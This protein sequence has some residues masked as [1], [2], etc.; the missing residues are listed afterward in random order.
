VIESWQRRHSLCQLASLC[1]HWE[2]HNTS[3]CHP[4]FSHVCDVSP[5]S[6]PPN[7]KSTVLPFVNSFVSVPW[8]TL[9]SCRGSSL[10]TG[11]GSVGM[12]PRVNDSLRSGRVQDVSS[13]LH[14]LV[15]ADVANMT[16]Q[17]VTKTRV[18][19]LPMFTQRSQLAQ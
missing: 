5:G 13:L 11:V 3:F 6:L 2:L 10:G 14:F 12:I 4:L 15:H 8:M 18:V 17:G 9:P 16:E 1:E 19:Q 7:R